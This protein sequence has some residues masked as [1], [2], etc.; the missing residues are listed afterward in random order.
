[1]KTAIAS[2]L[3]SFTL[4]ACGQGSD[5]PIIGKWRGT[6]ENGK[7]ISFEFKQDSMYF[8]GSFAAMIERYETEGDK[9]LVFNT[10]EP[11]KPDSFKIVDQDTIELSLGP[12]K[13]QLNRVD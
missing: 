4:A 8:D 6:A 12:I 7:V 9:V 1:M 13:V 2:I 5:Y 10:S 3:M 11:N